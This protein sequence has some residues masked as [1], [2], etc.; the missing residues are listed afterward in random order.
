VS[1]ETQPRRDWE[2]AIERQI[3]EA[4]ERGEFDHLPGAG[5]PL[6]LDE[7]PYTPEDW[8]LAFKVLKDAGVAP[9]WIEQSKEIRAE[10]RALA[11]LLEQQT[12]WQRERIVKLQALSPDQMIAEREHLVEARAR[13]CRAY[14]QRATALN[15]MIDTFN[16]RVP[17]AHLQLP[18]VRIEEEL[19]RFQDACR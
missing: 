11:T 15:Q 12:L 1:D 5:K 14:R 9:A 3:R 2:S 6:N 10:L 19:Q 7:N 8:R 13:T 18:R 16:L 17:S 4:M